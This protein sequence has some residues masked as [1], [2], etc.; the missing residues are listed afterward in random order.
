M[1][2]FLNFVIIFCVVGTKTLAGG[3]AIT[4]GSTE[5]TQLLNNGQLLDISTKSTGQL[6]LTAQ[7]YK[8]QLQQLASQLKG[9]Q[10]MV[11]NTNSLPTQFIQKIAFPILQLRRVH[12]D[13]GSIIAEGTNIDEALSQ[14]MINDEE[15]DF[16]GY[17][18]NNFSAR[19]GEQ[20]DIWNKSLSSGLR[21][22]KLNNNNIIDDAEFLEKITAS[23]GD[24][25]GRLQV[26]QKANSISANLGKQ[27]V[28]LQTLT[29]SHNEAIQVGWSRVLTD[30]DAKQAAQE[31][32]DQATKQ[33]LENLDNQETKTRTIN[34]VLG[35]GN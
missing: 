27:L 4:G 17:S 35:I 34:E 16:N 23:L 7:S 29:S 33:N 10:N 20:K 19:Y 6:K 11:Q 8:T 9:Y 25:D 14:L 5:W 13:V 32:F 28:S 30:M 3:G 12:S 2:K 26:L 31:Q 21:T 18:E 24:E 15:F 1:V 22:L